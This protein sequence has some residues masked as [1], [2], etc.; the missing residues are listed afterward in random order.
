MEAS[1][2]RCVRGVDDW[3][4]LWSSPR[5][6]HQWP[7]EPFLKWLNEQPPHISL[8]EVGCGNGANLR[9]T[10]DVQVVA[11]VD[12][13]REAIRRA[14]FRAPWAT[15]KVADVCDLPF[16]DD[17]FDAVADI[18]CLQHIQ[19]QTT[20]WAEITRVLRPGGQVFSMWLQ[21]GRD[22]YPDLTFYDY[23]LKTMNDLGLSIENKGFTS[24]GWRNTQ[25]GHHLLTLRFTG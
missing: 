8:L 9:A 4:S 5:S 17:L 2:G 11:G 19:D 14:T 25:V 16:T 7:A 13:S 21:L 20:A 18:Q 23:N 1:G 10:D 12:I 15:L 22:Q 6:F 3:E 24:R